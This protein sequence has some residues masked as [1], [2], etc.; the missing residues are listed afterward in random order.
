MTNVNSYPPDSKFM[1]CFAVAG[2]FVWQSSTLWA[3]V[4]QNC[5]IY[6]CKLTDNLRVLFYC[7]APSVFSVLLLLLRSST[8]FKIRIHTASA[9][10]VPES[11]EGRQHY[12]NDNCV[13]ILNGVANI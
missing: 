10:S 12:M 7:R 9:L 3:R 2:D 11:R 1:L 13:L 8:N 5:N 4:I 6:I